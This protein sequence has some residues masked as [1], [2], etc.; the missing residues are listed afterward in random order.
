[1][2]RKLLCLLILGVLM[3]AAAGTA[4]ASFFA[5]FIDVGAG[6]CTLLIADGE[7]MLVDTGPETALRSVTEALQAKNIEKIDTLVITHPHRDHAGNLQDVLRMLP[8]GRGCVTGEDDSKEGA[9]TEQVILKAGYEPVRLYRGDR[10]TFGS[11]VVTVL[12]P[13]KGSMPISLND[14]SAVMRI[15]WHGFS[16]LLA[17][18]AEN[19]AEACMLRGAADMELKSDMLRV[20]H[21]GM[22][23]A[24]SWPFAQAVGANYAVISC[25]E[26]TAARPHLS[27]VTE[28]TL[29]N[30][31]AAAVLS[32]LHN[33]NI[34]L[35]IGDDRRLTITAERTE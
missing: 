13:E 7:T 31:G 11:G 2:K 3:C 34:R 21:H 4:S 35:E 18:D 19:G 25:G 9:E 32:T 12:W 8:V 17:G 29:R 33:G 15:V 23:T 5:Q 16:L 26:P 10:F 22:E 30:A 28:E 1:M 24:T 14:R 20:G 27:P 6:D